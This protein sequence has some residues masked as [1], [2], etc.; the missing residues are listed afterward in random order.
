VRWAVRVCG[1]GAGVAGEVGATSARPPECG[2]DDEAARFTWWLGCFSA[3]CALPPPPLIPLTSAA[4]VPFS[5]RFVW[6]SL[7]WCTLNPDGGWAHAAQVYADRAGRY[8]HGAAGDLE[9]AAQR[10]CRGP[11]Q[12][13]L[14]ACRG[15]SSSAPAAVASFLA[16]VLT[17]IYLCHHFWSKN[18]ETQRPRTPVASLRSRSGGTNIG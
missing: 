8:V 12:A 4:V 1:K 5:F 7:W 15:A 3:L 2:S 6:L 14:C 10:Y 17:E 9:Q 11:L 18:I 16:A 13:A